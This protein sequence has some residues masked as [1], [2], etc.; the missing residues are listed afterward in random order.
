MFIVGK[1]CGLGALLYTP[2]ACLLRE[3]HDSS[4]PNKADR[5]VVTDRHAEMDSVMRAAEQT[6]VVRAPPP[7]MITCLIDFIYLTTVSVAV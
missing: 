2:W 5:Q 1:I 4:T 7:P 3:I 6:S